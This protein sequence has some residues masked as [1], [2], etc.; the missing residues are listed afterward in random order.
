[1]GQGATLSASGWRQN[2]CEIVHIG[3][4]ADV[5]PFRCFRR[6]FISFATVAGA[7]RATVRTVREALNG[8]YQSSS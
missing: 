3:R 4:V 7:Y 8:Q 6:N 5:L 1:M 2:K